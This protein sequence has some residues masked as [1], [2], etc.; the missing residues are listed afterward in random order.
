MRGDATSG[1]NVRIGASFDFMGGRGSAIGPAEW[2]S[3]GSLTLAP[4]LRSACPKPHR[5]ND[6]VL[7]IYLG[8]RVNWMN[9]N[10]GMSPES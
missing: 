10:F 3:T 6:K 4:F 5:S 1:A 7:L 8:G 9:L 2:P